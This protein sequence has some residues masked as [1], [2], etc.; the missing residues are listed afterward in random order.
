MNVEEKRA[1][2]E[3]IIPIV[4]EFLLKGIFEAIRREIRNNPLPKIVAQSCREVM[5][6]G[7]SETK[8]AYYNNLADELEKKEDYE[9]ADHARLAG[10]IADGTVICDRPEHEL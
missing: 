3:K 5:R 9:N 2:D 6:Q 7:T 8:A 1:A 4:A 10:F